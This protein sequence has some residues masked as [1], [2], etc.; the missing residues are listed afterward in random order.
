VR[1]WD[2]KTGEARGV[3]KGHKEWIT[4]IAWRPAHVESPARLFVTGSKDGSA[5]VW[6]AQSK[7][8][9]FCLGGHTR[10]VSAVKWGGGT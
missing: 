8:L 7:L 5:R 10:A 2:P 9:V 6:N 1:L 3:C 4:S